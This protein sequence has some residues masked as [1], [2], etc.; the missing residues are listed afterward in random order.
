MLRLFGRAIR[1]HQLY[2]H[3]NPTYIRSLEA[4]KGAFLPIWKHA[5][6]IIIEVADTQLTWEGRTVL[7]EPDKTTDALPWILYKD[8]VRELRLI[9]GIED[10]ELVGLVD[11]LARVRKAG[12][13]EDD[14]LALLWEKEFNFVRYRYVDLLADGIVPLDL[15]EDINDQK[16]VDPAQVREP[17]KED[18]LPQGVVKLDDFN[19]TL[20]FLEEKEIEYLRTSIQ[21]EYASDLR[22][23]VVDMLL[24]TYEQ[25]LDPTIRDEICGVLDILLVNLLTAGQL[26]TT[27]ALLRE[28]ALAADRGRDVTPAQ[29]ERLLQLADRLSEPEA[30]NQLLQSIDERVESTGQGELNELFEQLRMGALGTIFSWLSKTQHARMRSQLEHAAARLAS[31]HTAELVRLISSSERPVSLE[32]M[33]RAGAMKAAA[34]VP[35]LGRMAQQADD[36]VRLTA[37]QAL[38]EVGSPGALQFLER[39]LDDASRDV[40]VASARAFAVRT[41]RPAL[42]KL[43]GMIKDR[44]VETADLTEKMAVFEAYGAMCGDAGVP[45]LDGILNG[46]GLFGRRED[47]E[48]RACAARALGKVG[49]GAA[50][51]ALQKAAN[52]KEIL[53][54]NA[55]T[56]GLRGGGA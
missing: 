43:E 31:A 23:N 26:G 8:G 2:L 25:Q 15:S 52:D 49:S 47:P 3:N 32:A 1:A 27:A 18:L 6:E 11:V 46:K 42:T 16:L 40:R 29:K 21:K 33:R 56:R 39:T 20:Y 44:K 22:R 45:L 54:R 7:N 17:P 51:G 10:Q 12:A 9:K 53:V 41:H 34:A 13:D 5:E 35:G 50:T 28:A 55:V 4:A 19:T 14:L 30:L 37:V 38:A 24:D 36:E 48:M